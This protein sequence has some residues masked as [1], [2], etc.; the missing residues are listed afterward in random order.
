M[1]YFFRLFGMILIVSIIL[2]IDLLTADCIENCDT[3]GHKEY[4]TMITI[5][6]ENQEG[7]FLFFAISLTLFI[8]F[9]CANYNY[10]HRNEDIL[11]KMS[12]VDSNEKLDALIEKQDALNKK[13]I[14]ELSNLKKI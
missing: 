12:N 1:K 8:L 7:V 14:F 13:S 4:D 2:I 6:N 5:V 9:S 10:K 3:Y 11:I